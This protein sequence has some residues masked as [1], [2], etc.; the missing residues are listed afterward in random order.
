VRTRVASLDGLRGLA[1]LAV[2][3]YHVAP[4]VFP[5]GFLGVD[6]FFVLSGFLLTTLLL[7]EHVRTGTI[8]RLDYA[9]RRVRRIAPA[10][11]VLLAALVVIVPLAVPDDVHRLPGD[12]VSSVLGL[13]NW[14]LIRDGSSYFAQAGR[15]SFVRHLWSIAV[16]VQFYVLCPFLVGWLAR[17]RPKVAVGALLAG[18]AASATLMGLLYTS[19]DPSRAYFGTDT[20]IHALLMGCLVAVL[21]A[22]RPF[23]GWIT[24]SQG[25][26]HP[27]ND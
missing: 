25:V 15:P 1:L 11:L 2:L 16:E 5:G 10:L 9:V 4:G 26:S 17:R 7:G 22:H 23:S 3:A 8:D 18:I 24:P 21:L 20:R 14:H 19:P 12:I 6:I 27:E 13:T